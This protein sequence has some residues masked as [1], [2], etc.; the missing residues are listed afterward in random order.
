[1]LPPSESA[2][3]LRGL[4]IHMQLA[5]RIFLFLLTN[6]LIIATISIV[7]SVL[8]VRPYLNAN[9]IDYSS[10]AVF[11]LIWG[12]GG[13]FISLLLSRWMAKMMMG[14]KVINPQQPGDAVWLLNM[15][16]QISKSAGLPRTPEVGIY[17][18]GELNAFATGPTKNR[19]L[20]AFSSGLLNQMSRDEIEG[21]AAHEVAHIANGDM[22]TLTLIQG[23]VN[24]FVMFIA[25]VVA[26]FVGQQVREESRYW[27][28][29]LVV[30]V[31]DIM[32]SILASMVVAAFSRQREFRADAGSASYVGREK[33]IA[34]L[35]ALQRAY[36]RL[37]TAKDHASLEPMKISSPR[38][39]WLGL[40]RTHPPLEDRIRALQMA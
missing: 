22:V 38:K 18:S 26:F 16:E 36:G 12:M 33:M 34:G 3:V 23:V 7:M 31:L 35:K 37:D 14:V 13:A 11:C 17:Q 25:R 15:V 40:L 27:V 10:L 24:A 30:I 32:L 5:K 4:E 29:T 21:V 9:G 39:S 1:M 2:L 20:V 28:Q 8:G 19:A 6:I